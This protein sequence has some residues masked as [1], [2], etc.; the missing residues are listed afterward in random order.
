MLLMWREIYYK[1]CRE[2]SETLSRSHYDLPQALRSSAEAENV[3]ITAV[4]GLIP[5]MEEQSKA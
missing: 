5:K 3:K 4:Q 2:Q 1:V